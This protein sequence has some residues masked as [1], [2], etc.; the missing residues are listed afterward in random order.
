MDGKIGVHSIEKEGSSFWFTLELP[1]ADHLIVKN[2]LAKENDNKFNLNVLVVDDREINLKVAS[3]MLKKLG[4]K[5]ETASNG[6]IAINKYDSDPEKYDLIIMDIQMPIMDGL[7][8]TKK[9]R[10]KYPNNLAP[11]YGLSAQVSENLHKSPEE[12]GFDFYLTK[13]L[14]LETLQ[15]SLKRLTEIG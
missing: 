15:N 12:L 9:L 10:E 8:A 1:I 5:V 4:C 11:V 3:L 6:E 14:S 2:T 13:P 7:T